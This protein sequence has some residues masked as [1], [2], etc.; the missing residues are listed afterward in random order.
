M[1]VQYEIVSTGSQG[2]AVVFNNL[3]ILDCGVSFRRIKPFLKGIRIVLLTHIHSDHF[4]KTT[5]KQIAKDRPLV[6][7]GCG[8]WLVSDLMECGVA[9]NRIDVF[10]EGE[11]YDYGLFAL[12]PVFL[13]HNVP[14]LGY[15]LFFPDGSVFYATDC[16]NLNGI[17]APGFD[18]YMVEA[19]HTEEDIENR[20]RAKKETG[21]FAYE[22]Q[23]K[24]NHLSKEQCDAF[25]YANIKPGGEFVYLHCHIDKGG[26]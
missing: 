11:R 18:L 22:I 26:G 16:A 4:N 3:L 12:S 1:P 7:F 2:N 20:I 13:T 6:R 5:I 24:Q 10:K 8:E 23:A 21:E 17:F 15:K 25:I 19:N 9:R 14:N